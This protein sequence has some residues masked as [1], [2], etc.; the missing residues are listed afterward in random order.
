[1]TIACS[2]RD[3]SYWIGASDG[4]AE[5]IFRWIDTTVMKWA[6]WMNAG[7]RAHPLRNFMLIDMSKGKMSVS[8]ASDASPALCQTKT[9]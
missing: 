9:G 8:K 4:I 1:M 7:P 2:K 6:D 3:G 5:G